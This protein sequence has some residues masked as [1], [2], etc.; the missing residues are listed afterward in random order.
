[1]TG[2]LK[3]CGKVSGSVI[4]AGTVS[5]AGCTRFDGG[6]GALLAGVTMLLTLGQD[7]DGAS[8]LMHGGCSGP[9]TVTSRD[10]RQAVP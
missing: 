8:Q 6:R 5:F 10:I 9:W 1:M 3:F 2:G 7:Y 4:V